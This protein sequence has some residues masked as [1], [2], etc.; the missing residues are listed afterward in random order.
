M[1]HSNRL[2]TATL[3]D[4]HA[5]WFAL[6]AI[7]GVGIAIIASRRATLR[8][9]L[10]ALV[11]GLILLLGAGALQAARTALPFVD[12]Q[13]FAAALQPY[14]NRPL[15][16]ASKY[17]GEIGYLARLEQPLELID[18]DA[19]PG[20]FA[21]HPNGLV[22]MRHDVNVAPTAGLVVL[23]FPYKADQSFDV[24]EKPVRQASRLD[25]YVIDIASNY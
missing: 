1:K 3:H 24:L 25:G 11:T 21:A 12:L 6:A 20:W 18:E 22:I 19:I 13:P 4:Y 23:S 10:I 8:A 17:A 15:A 5:G 14:K 2:I 9:Q 16:Y 7:W